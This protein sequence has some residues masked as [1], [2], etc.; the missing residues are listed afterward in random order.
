MATP[1]TAFIIPGPTCSSSTPGL[2]D[3]RAYPSAACAAACSCRAM[4]NPM[5][6]RPSASSSAMLVC[7]QVP[8]TYRTPYDSSWAAS[9]SAAVIM[10]LH[11]GWTRIQ[12]LPGTA[13]AARKAVS[14]SAIG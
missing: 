13:A 4:T 2:P 1:V 6:L 3:T 14:A 5:R 9:A 7:P 11:G 12:V 10:S 8:N